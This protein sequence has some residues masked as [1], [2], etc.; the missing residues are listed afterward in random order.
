L[1]SA[2]PEVAAAGRAVLEAARA[3]VPEMLPAA[4]ASKMRRG[5]PGEIQ[6]VVARLCPL[7][8]ETASAT[9]VISQPV[10]LVRYDRGALERVALALAYEGSDPA[11]HAFALSGSLRTGKEAALVELLRAVLR[12]RGPGELVPRA[13]E[14]STLTFEIMADALTAQDLVGHRRRAV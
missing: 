13:F 11:I 6:A 14:S 2:Q 4:Q 5:A 10:R 1:S 9:M 3:T 12:E 7:P 8:E